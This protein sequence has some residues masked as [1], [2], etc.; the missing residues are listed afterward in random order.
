[1][2]EAARAGIH[3]GNISTVP[4]VKGTLSFDYDNG[5]VSTTL[6]ANYVHHYWQEF[7]DGTRFVPGDPRFQTGVYPDQVPR[8]I[9]YD[10]FAKYSVTKNLDISGSILN[11]TNQMPPYDP[12]FSATFLY[13]FEQLD[14]R[15]RQF[16]LGLHY[17]M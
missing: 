11:F 6:A 17:K 4:R 9:S 15:G 16:R 3:G 1:L 7:L 2:Q 5:P 8:Y 13:N 12:G 14:I 10:F